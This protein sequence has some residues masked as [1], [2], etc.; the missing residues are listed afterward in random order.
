MGCGVREEVAYR[1]TLPL[2]TKECTILRTPDWR[3]QQP[4]HQPCDDQ[5]DQEFG[6]QQAQLKRW[7][8]FEG[9]A[10]CF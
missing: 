6:R 8:T 2:N 9:N 1:D 5:H 10:E 7:Q 4:H 3:N